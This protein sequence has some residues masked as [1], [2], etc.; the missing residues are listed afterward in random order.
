MNQASTEKIGIFGGTFDPVHLGHLILAETVRDECG[1]DEIHFIPAKRPPHKKDA[2]IAPDKQRV[3]MLEFALAGHGKFKINL[4]EIKRDGLSYTVDTLRHLREARP[5]VEFSLLIGADS[6][7]DFPTWREPEQILELANVIAVNRGQSEASLEPIKSA[8][9]DQ[10][11]QRIQIVEMP[12][13]DISAT[14]LR[15][16]VASQRSIRFLTPRP[17]ELF[18]QENGLYQ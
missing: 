16:R 12:M 13:I 8:L 11:A 4:M 2:E 5:E 18:I 7:H 6:L 10:A 15:Q 17:V 14:D 1:L 9:G 3:K